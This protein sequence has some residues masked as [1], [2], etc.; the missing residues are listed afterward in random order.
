[1]AAACRTNQPGRGNKTWGSQRFMALTSQQRRGQTPGGVDQGKP[2][3]M[4]HPPSQGH[5]LPAC[6]HGCTSK[7]YQPP[8][9]SYQPQ[10]ERLLPSTAGAVVPLSLSQTI[11]HV[12][13]KSP[14]RRLLNEY[15]SVE[16]RKCRVVLRPR[17]RLISHLLVN[18]NPDSRAMRSMRASVRAWAWRGPGAMS[19][20]PSRT[21]TV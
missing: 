19:G 10:E 6:F 21:C 20:G 11:R 1:M 5:K 2:Q 12:P 13:E 16:L 9:V 17:K 3:K 15:F 8:A 18:Q 14:L 4:D 7:R